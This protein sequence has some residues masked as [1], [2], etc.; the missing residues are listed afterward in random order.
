MRR[1]W[2]ATAVAGLLALGSFSVLASSP[3]KSL[4]AQGEAALNAIKQARET[5]FNQLEA[6]LEAT[7]VPD[8]KEE[9][10]EAALK[11][12]EASINAIAGPAILKLNAALEA[13][14]EDE[15]DGSAGADQL[16]TAIADAKP[17]PDA[18]KAACVTANANLAKALSTL[19]GTATA[20]R[21]DDEDEDEDMEVER[22][23]HHQAKEVEHE[24]KDLAEKDNEKKHDE[25]TEHE[26]D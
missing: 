10:A 7:P 5:C 21:N 17:V 1:A 15:D 13:F 23:N 3:E 25:K 18:I 26:D 24:K 20:A 19:K 2:I 16:K 6:T 11:A 4:E 9:M 8:Q 14:D 12:A 22:D